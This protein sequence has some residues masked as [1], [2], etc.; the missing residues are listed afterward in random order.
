MIF[1]QSTNNYSDK[2]KLPLL[3]LALTT[4]VEAYNRNIS[5]FIAITK[6][7]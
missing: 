3:Q 2:S 1:Q 4:K 5:T 7:C 6:F